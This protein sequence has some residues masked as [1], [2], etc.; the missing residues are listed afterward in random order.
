MIFAFVE[1][2]TLEL[3]DSAAEA[4]RQYEGI[5]V[6]GGIVRFY[7]E[8]GMYLEPI[9]KTPNRTGKILGVLGWVASGT[10]DLV[11]NPSA[12]QNSFALALF[13]TVTLAPNRWFSS[14]EHLK[15]ELSIQGVQ[16]EFKASRAGET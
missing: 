1:D 10:Y 8:T 2:G 5:D 12:D 6:E 9:F 7:D 14:I 3:I 11:S 4:Q 13:E 16:V 15:S